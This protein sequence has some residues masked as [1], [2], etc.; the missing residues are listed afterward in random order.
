MIVVLF[1]PVI[2]FAIKKARIYAIIMLGAAWLSCFFSP[3][4]HHSQLLTAFFFFSWGAYMSI[5]E[6][7]MLAIFGKMFKASTISYLCLAAAYAIAYVYCQ[8][9]TILLKM[10][11]Q[12]A[13]LIFAYNL[14]AWLLRKKICKVNK[15]LS[16]ASFFVYITHALIAA[17]ILPY[18][19]HNATSFVLR[20]ISRFYHGNVYT[21]CNCMPP[22]RRFLPDA[23]LHAKAFESG[24]RQKIRQ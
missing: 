17:Q 24:C 16:S 8:K 11:N 23:P 10:F 19:L 4:G 20:H 3:Y 5:S 7:D 12:C 2:H 14:S 21:C 6:K 13:G 1:T 22:S 9:A 18:I 15:F